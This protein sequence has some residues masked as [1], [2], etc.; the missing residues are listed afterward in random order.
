MEVKSIANGIVIDHV[1]AGFGMKVLEYLNVDTARDTVA[2]LMNVPSEKHGRK[3]IIKLEN[4]DSVDV[5]VLGLVDHNATVI[6]IKN[7]EIAEKIKLKFPRRVKNVIKCK[8]PRCVT[9]I[10]AVRHVF[11]LVDDSGKYR[12]E[13][14]DNIVKADEY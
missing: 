5:K 9:S 8:N 2:L 11:H 13:Y 7:S 10:E 12:C 4:I 1:R 3:D 14:C 6:Y